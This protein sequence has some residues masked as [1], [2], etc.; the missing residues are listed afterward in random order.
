MALDVTPQ[1]NIYICRTPLEADYEN[2]LTFSSTSAQSTYFASTVVRSFDNSTYI[3]KDQG[4]K[5]NCNVEDIRNCNYLYYRNTG[6]SNKTYY[7][8]ITDIQYISENS[9]YVA[10]ETDVWQTWYFDMIWHPCLVERE[11]VIDDRIGVNTYPEGLEL[12]PEYRIIRAQNI[13]PTDDYP[14]IVWGVTMIN[15]DSDNGT[16]KAEYLSDDPFNVFNGTASGLYYIVQNYDASDS[17]DNPEGFVRAYDLAGLGDAI[18]TAFMIPQGFIEGEVES[19]GFQITGTN[20]KSGESYTQHNLYMMKGSF[21]AKKVAN[22]DIERDYSFGTFGSTVIESKWQIHNNKL[23]CY[24]YQY[25][26]I[27]NNAGQTYNYHYEDFTSHLR[28]TTDPNGEGEVVNPSFTLWFAMTPGGSTKLVP[29]QDAANHC[30]KDYDAFREDYGE[31]DSA[32]MDYGITGAKYPQISWSNDAYT[33]WLTQNGVNLDVAMQK[34]YMTNLTSTVNSG[35]SGLAANG[36]E[37]GIL[38]VG[39][40]IISSLGRTFNTAATNYAQV[41]SAKMLPDQVGGNTN[42]GDVNWSMNQNVFTCYQMSIRGEYARIIDGFF[43]RFG[44]KVNALRVP[45]RTSRKNWN[46]IKTVEANVDGDIPQKDLNK[47]RRSLNNGITLWHNPSTMYD[48]TQ[49]NSITG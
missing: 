27:S 11:H 16:L 43:D 31:G 39:T 10:I 45:Q 34:T 2:Q 38:G 47:I 18:V 8:F 5:I 20:S 23:W 33:N 36:I 26:M 49:D 46:F 17:W 14:C 12:G 19:T 29:R 41:E 22:Y 3:R 44:Y 13:G 9:T 35:L 15:N 37:G 7:C 25:L 6:F 28:V 40:G 24:P 21:T 30:Y 42:S 32:L 48:Y 4:L 1:G